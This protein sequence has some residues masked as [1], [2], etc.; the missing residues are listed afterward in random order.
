MPLKVV[1]LLLLALGLAVIGYG[2]WQRAL[3][4]PRVIATSSHRFVDKAG[5]ELIFAKR[6]VAVAGFE[7]TEVQLPGGTW[8][9]CRS[10]CTAA[11]KAEYTEVWDQRMLGRR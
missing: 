1:P 8:I 6:Q 2:T 4:P 11:I 10:D 7:V 3:Y 5:T 9:D